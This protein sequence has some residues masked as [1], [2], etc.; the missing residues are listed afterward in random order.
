MSKGSDAP[1]SDENYFCHIVIPSKDYRKSRIFFERAF[2]WIVQKAPVPGVLDVLPPSGK[3]PSAELN[4]DE[5]VVVPAIRTRDIERK[6][7]TIVEN[8]GKVLKGKTPIDVKGRHGFYA[9]FEDPNGNRM[10][11]YQEL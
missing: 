11:L 3:G 8:G 6:L 1:E 7:V 2:G 5:E 9:L 10:A 4:S